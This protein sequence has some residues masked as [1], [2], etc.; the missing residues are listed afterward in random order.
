MHVST[1]ILVFEKIYNR[2]HYPQIWFLRGHFRRSNYINSTQTSSKQGVNAHGKSIFNPEVTTVY[3]D[4]Q[5]VIFVGCCL[6]FFV[7]ASAEFRVK[8]S[9]FLWPTIG[10]PWAFLRVLIE[11]SRCGIKLVDNVSDS[12]LRWNSG[13]REFDRKISSNIKKSSIPS[14]SWMY[15]VKFIDK[16]SLTWRE[17]WSEHH[18]RLIKKKLGIFYSKFGVFSLACIN[19]R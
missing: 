7:Y 14:P 5:V 6:L 18:F 15:G 9:Q 12:L 17:L 10:V 2:G 1:M 3:F 8:T 13:L 19:K 11:N 16:R 4:L